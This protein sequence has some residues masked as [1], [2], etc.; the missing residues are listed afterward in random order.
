MPVSRVVVDQLK[1]ALNEEVYEWSRG[2]KV[3][4][5]RESA[6]S[7]EHVSVFGSVRGCAPP[8]DAGVIARG[9]NDVG[10]PR[11]K[12]SKCGQGNL[13]SGRLRHGLIDAD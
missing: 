1:A 10:A 7:R 8:Q 11:S 5:E 3:S 2:A 4:E 12:V 6:V 13:N 9:D